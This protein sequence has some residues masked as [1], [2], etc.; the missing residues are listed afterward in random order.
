MENEQSLYHNENGEILT[1]KM[2][3]ALSYSGEKATNINILLNLPHNIYSQE[4]NIFIENMKG[5]GTPYNQDFNLYCLN[6]EFPYKNSFDLQI[7]YYNSI[8]G[9][10][11]FKDSR[12]IIKEV[13]LPR[14]FQFHCIPPVKNA[15]FKI[16]IGLNQEIQVNKFSLIF[17]DLN[18][19]YFYTYF[20]F[21]YFLLL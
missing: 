18:L 7:S 21:I 4:N 9:K 1:V 8:A 10:P 16:T 11:E 19:F 13:N 14:N 15:S 20:I 5:G 6:S 2:R 3:I 17:Y 12:C